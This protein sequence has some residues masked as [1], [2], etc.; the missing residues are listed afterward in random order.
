MPEAA[1]WELAFRRAPGVCVLEGAFRCDVARVGVRPSH[2]LCVSV[3]FGCAF[4]R[5][6]ALDICGCAFWVCVLVAFWFVVARKLCATIVL[7]V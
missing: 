4:W 1:F 3:R 7:S 5:V 6:P 2:N